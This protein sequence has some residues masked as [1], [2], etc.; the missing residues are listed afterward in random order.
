MRQSGSVAL[1][2]RLRLKLTDGE[3][4]TLLPAG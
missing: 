1:A 3:G 2:V 4:N